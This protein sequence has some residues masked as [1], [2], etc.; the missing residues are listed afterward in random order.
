M[1]L[2]QGSL[3]HPN[4]GPDHIV[5]AYMLDTF[6]STQPVPPVMAQHT[7]W[8]YPSHGQQVETPRMPDV[9]MSW[10]FTVESPPDGNGAMLGRPSALA[11]DRQCS[12][13]DKPKCISPHAGYAGLTGPTWGGAFCCANMHLIDGMCVD[14]DTPY[15]APGNLARHGYHR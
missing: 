14:S 5:N 13:R 8:R 2:L 4:V 9:K 1:G 11:W 7:L 10:A 12:L 3:Y 15:C 6:A